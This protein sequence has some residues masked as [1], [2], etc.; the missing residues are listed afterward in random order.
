MIKV[1]KETP[2]TFGGIDCLEQ[3]VMDDD[4]HGCE[5]CDLCA[6]RGWDD[7][8]EMQANCVDVHGCTYLANAYFLLSQLDRYEAER[9][10]RKGHKTY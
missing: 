6:Y 8:Q 4:M 5:A 7:Y 2:T 1:L 10:T 9:I 3:L